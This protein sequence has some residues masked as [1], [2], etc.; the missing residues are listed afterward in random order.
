MPSPER[1]SG[2]EAEH[3]PQPYYQA[4]RF[5][6][7][8]FAGRAYRQA[9]ATIYNAKEE[10]DLSSYRFHLNQIWHVA[11]FGEQPPEE[12][13]R[14]IQQILSVGAPVPLPE[15]VLK[16]LEARRAQAT[17]LGSWVEGHYHPGRRLRRDDVQDP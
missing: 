5:N 7:E 17:Q 4:A 11:T 10:V 13:E 2:H 3:E 16:L 9:Q 15:D 14:R 8:R 6:S 12:I 1:P